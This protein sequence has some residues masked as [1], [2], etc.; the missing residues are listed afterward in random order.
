M[1][2]NKWTIALTAAGVVSA[3]SIGQ[4]EERPMS[5]VLTGVSGTTIS[6][7][8]DTSAIW[9]FGTGTSRDGMSRT[10]DFLPGRFNDGADKTDGFNLHVVG[11]S[12]GRPLGEDNWAAGYQVDLLFGPDAIGYNP[13]AGGAEDSDFAIKQA[14]VNLR[15]PMGTGLDV[16]MGVFNTILG[17]ESFQSYLNPNFSRSFGWQLE[18][19]QHT[20]ILAS[21]QLTEAVGVSAGIANTH[22]A[23]INSRSP[24]AES[25]KTYMAGIE[26]TAPDSMGFMAGSSFYAGVM[27][28]FSGNESDTTSL[29]VGGSLLTPIEGL[30][31]GAAFDYRVDGANDVTTGSNWAY[32]VAGY[33]TFRATEKLAFSGRADYTKGSDGTWFDAGTAGVSDTQNELFAATLT[34]EY[35]LWANVIT[36]AEFRWDHSLSDDSPYGRRDD[37]ALTLAA[38]VVFKF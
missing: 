35:A 28:G 38:N 5:Q 27:D 33:L 20:G 30:Q 22:M 24:R 23:G 1:K 29:Y 37:N 10:P 21:Y 31:I 16:K 8:V 25:H 14:Y 34:A 18:P 13:S 11:L 2:L 19:T 36:R 9:K 32:A 26:F 7:Y 15:L 3:A 4:A 12:V 17:Y 6:G